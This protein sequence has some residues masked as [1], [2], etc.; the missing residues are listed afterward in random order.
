MLKL[1]DQGV[2]NGKIAKTVFEEMY[3]S[4]KPAET[5]VRE[6]GLTQITDES[7]IVKII[8]D[9]MT[10]N[11]GQLNDYRNGKDKLFGFFVGQVMKATQGQAN[12]AVVNQLLKE[13]LGPSSA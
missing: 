2:I 13:K 7:K 12:P 9:I 8:E 10:A 11:P 5:I 6:K 4:G 3:K 1:V